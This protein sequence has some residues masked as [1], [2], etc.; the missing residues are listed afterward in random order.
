M[1]KVTLND[2]ANLLDFTTAATTI[3]GNSDTIE[4]A[5]DNTLSRDGTTPNQMEAN[6]DMNSFNIINLPAPATNNSPLRLQDLTDF[7]GTGTVNLL[8]TGGTTGQALSKTS[9]ADYAVGWTDKVTSVGLSLPSDFNV[10][11][12][13]VN[14]SGTLTG[15]W[16]TTPTGTGAVV[17]AT[18]PTLVT[19]ALG[20]PSSATLTN[21]TGLP[22]STGVSGLGANVATFLATPSSAN[23]SAAVTD[24]TGVGSLVFATGPTMTLTNATGLPVS[25]GISGLGTG[26]ATF[27]ATPSSANLASALT[28]ETGTGVA[29][30]GTSPTITTPNIVGTT[31][32]GNA[33]AGSV[34]EI[35]ESDIAVGSAVSLTSGVTVNVTS[36]SL[37]AGDWDVEGS[38]TFNPGAT[39][40]ITAI[41]AGISSTSA[42]FANKPSWSH[43]IAAFVPAA[44]LG[45]YG[46]TRQRF[47]VS[48]TTTVYLVA[49]STFTVSTN[50]AYGYI[51]ARRVR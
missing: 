39:T 19:P 16:A 51:S 8:P 31:A 42:T 44:P 45:G 33:S 23:L 25:T 46:L 5:F 34:G 12:S 10:T 28:D 1:T 48:S 24:E 6:I 15:T 47:N 26:V 36:I 50:A 41:L 4:T 17:R 9:N 18:S 38:V 30:F 27:L 11:G 21:A 3:N 40:S 7:N 22:I 43:R 37:T 32:V 49:Q 13:P 35:I 29:V 14:S 2:V 20:T